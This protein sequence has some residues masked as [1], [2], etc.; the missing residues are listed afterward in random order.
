VLGPDGRDIDV[1]IVDYKASYVFAPKR[2]GFDRRSIELSQKRVH[3]VSPVIRPLARGSERWIF[4]AGRSLY[5]PALEP[6]AHSITDKSHWIMFPGSRSGVSRFSPRG[7]APLLA[8]SGPRPWCSPR[9]IQLSS[10][11]LA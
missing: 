4:A 1:L 3:N 8:I 2:E 6:V 10:G 9:A 5:H 11:G 7:G